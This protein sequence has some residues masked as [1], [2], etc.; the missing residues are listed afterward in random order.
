MDAEMTSVYELA[1][2]MM[3]M[4]VVIAC[5]QFHIYSSYLKG[6]DAMKLLTSP[7]EGS[8]IITHRVDCCSRV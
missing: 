3:G 2:Y 1:V 7:S 8:I 4:K 5:M 6:M